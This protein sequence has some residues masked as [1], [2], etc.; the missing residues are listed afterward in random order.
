MEI[1]NSSLDLIILAL[2]IAVVALLYFFLW[3][4]LRV[5]SFD[6]RQT[7]GQQAA[8]SSP[9]GQLLVVVPGQ[10]GLASG[11]SF[12]LAQHNSFGRDLDNTIALNDNFLSS[13]HALLELRGDQ[14]ILE[15]L[16]STNGTYIN[17]VEARRPVVVTYGDTIRVGRVELKIDR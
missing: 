1:A 15:D 4:V 17:G 12:P 13:R 14:W 5:V 3:Q 6:L 9:Y 2:R 10:S 8:Q 11:K 7:G 16:G